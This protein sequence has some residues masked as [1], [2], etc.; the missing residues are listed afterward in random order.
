MNNFFAKNFLSVKKTEEIEAERIE[1]LIKENFNELPS[2]ISSNKEKFK[3]W[4]E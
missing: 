3:D 2:Y 1:K 4:L